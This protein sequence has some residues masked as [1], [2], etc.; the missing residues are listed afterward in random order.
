MTSSSS[1]RFAPF[2]PVAADADIRL[3]R[4]TTARTAATVPA[5]SQAAQ[6]LHGTL[7]GYAET[8]LISLPDVARELGL[9]TLQVKDESARLG[10]PSFKILGASWAVYHALSARL[11][12]RPPLDGGVEAL[13]EAFDP[14]RPLTLVA[15]TDGNHGRALARVARLFGFDAK[16]L[17]PADMARP[18]IDAIAAEGAEVEVIDGSYDLAVE[19]AAAYA[20][21]RTIVVADTAWDGYEQVPTWISEGYATIFWE[22]DAA[23]ERNGAPPPDLVVVQVGVGA[24]ARAV[25]AHY[26]RDGLPVAPTI[27]GVEPLTAACALET[28]VAGTMAYVPGPH[29]SVMAGLNAGRV[30]TVALPALVGGIDAFA[31]IPDD[32]VYEAMRAFARNG[33]AVGE[34]GAAGLAALMCLP[35]S[36]WSALGVQP[37]H[38]LVL[39]TEG[40]T[41]PIAYAEAVGDLPRAAE[42][43]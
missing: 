2:A 31:A 37:Q 1:R 34:T 35:H 6:A 33:L 18:R 11:G 30:S 26:R 32:V 5:P 15:A 41:D 7:P 4:R 21:T 38:A 42:T 3:V 19:T 25:V 23:L 12:H 20:D 43:V 13:A 9:T 27:V 28:A 22:I 24:L 40:P 39:V 16:I 14:L 8:A 29:P 10:L 36:A 17:V